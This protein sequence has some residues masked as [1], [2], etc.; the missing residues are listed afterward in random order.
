MKLF[1]LIVLLFSFS[2][3]ASD[4][5]ENY[6]Q[7]SINSTGSTDKT[8]TCIDKEIEF[9]KSLI[10]EILGSNKPSPDIGRILKKISE[11]LNEEYMIGFESCAVYTEIYQ[12]GQAGKILQ[13][14]CYLDRIIYIRKFVHDAE[15][16]AS[17]NYSD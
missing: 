9:N 5:S 15:E 10:N 7:C 3:I 1:G 14:Q 11:N 4:Y 16:V 12:G 6:K 2:S 13:Y 8:L 17:F